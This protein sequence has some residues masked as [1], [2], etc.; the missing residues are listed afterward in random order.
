M[1]ERVAVASRAENINRVFL[2]VGVVVADDQHVGVNR[3]QR[4]GDE[5]QRGQRLLAPPVVETRLAIALIGVRARRS[6]AAF[7]AEMADDDAELVARRILLKSLRDR[8]AAVSPRRRRRVGQNAADRRDGGSAI[9]DAVFDVG[10][11]ADERRRIG[12]GRVSVRASAHRRR[13]PRG[14]ISSRAAVGRR[15]LQFD[16]SDHVGVQSGERGDHLVALARLFR[17]VVRPAIA[18]RRIGREKVVFDVERSDAQRTADRAGRGR[19]R[20]RGCEAQRQRGW[21][22]AIDTETE[23]E[24]AGEI[25]DA[26]AATDCSVC[27]RAD[28]RNR[29]WIGA[30]LAVVE[31]NPVVVVRCLLSGDRRHVARTGSRIAARRI[32]VRVNRISRNVKRTVSRQRQFAESAEVFVRGDEQSLIE[33]HAHAFEAFKVS[34]RR[35]RHRQ[36]DGRG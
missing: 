1:S 24:N 29:I 6:A 11:G 4:V 30:G 33:R 18:G 8:I 9:D 3:D 13:Q 2:P 5:R 21:L 7:R 15:L 19:A 17:S 14:Q 35:C 23:I 20:I 27:S 10:I 36:T 32:V 22:D 25:G 12:D 26:V 34:R 16:Q 31:C 28:E